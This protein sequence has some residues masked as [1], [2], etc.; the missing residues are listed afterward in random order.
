MK[1]TASPT[2]LRFFTSSSGMRTPNF[3]SAATTISTID[4]ESTSRSSTN[5]LSGWTSSA[6]TPAMSSTIAARSAWISVALAM[7]APC[8]RLSSVLEWCC[9]RRMQRAL[10]PG[11]VLS[12]DA[13]RARGG[14]GSGDGD[15]LGG[16]RQPGAEGDEERSIAALRLAVLE[17]AVEGEGDRGGGGVALVGDVT[18]DRD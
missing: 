14:R 6:A 10:R 1:E 5:D 12:G 4:N 3:S 2:V 16:V 11:A 17:Q 7:V 8:L 13:A 15:D 18:G 9:G